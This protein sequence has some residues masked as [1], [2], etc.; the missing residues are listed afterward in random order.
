MNDIQKVKIDKINEIINIPYEDGKQFIF[1]QVDIK[2]FE[3]GDVIFS[4]DFKNV[5]IEF[6]FSLLDECIDKIQRLKKE[7]YVN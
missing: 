7:F 1:V 2:T 4:M 6:S 3:H 5:F